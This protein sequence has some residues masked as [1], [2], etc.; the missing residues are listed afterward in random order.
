MGEEYKKKYKLAILKSDTYSIYYNWIDAINGSNY[1]I[2]YKV[3]DID[4]ELWLHHILST[5][6]DIIL[7]SPIFLV[8]SSKSMMDERLF[9]I[10]NILKI[11]TYPDTTV[12]LRTEQTLIIS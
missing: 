9:F 8:P 3:I 1:D 6:F 2:E 11:K 12:P 4:S 5:N 10:S 7:C